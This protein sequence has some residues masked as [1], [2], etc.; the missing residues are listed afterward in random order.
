[1]PSSIHELLIRG[2]EDAIRCQLKTICSGSDAAALFAQEVDS[3][4]SSIINFPVDG[5]PPTTKSKHEP[6]ASFWHAQAKYPGVIIEVAYSQKR[7]KVSRLAEDYLL[8]SNANVQVVVGLDIEY[9]GKRS[10]KA[11]LSV[12]R[13]HVIHTDDVDRLEVV[14]E[15]A[16]EAFRDDQGNPT[17]YPGL[18]LQ[19]SDFAFEGLTE[20]VV[21]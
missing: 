17:N 13:T 7:K 9:G 14:Q 12:W 3:A 18:R 5:A 16:D 15:V 21:K 1:M 10:Q 2:V 11:T 19:L 8:D 20:D 6:D 4:G